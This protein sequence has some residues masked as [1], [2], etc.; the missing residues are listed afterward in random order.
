MMSSSS[1]LAIDYGRKR[2]G[3]AVSRGSL[4]DPLQTLAMDTDFWQK[5]SQVCE[6]E[7]VKLVVVGVSEQDMACESRR[8]GEEVA[9]KIQL[10]VKFYD[11]TL[12]SVVVRGKLSQLKSSKSRGFIDHFAAA[13]ILQNFLDE[14]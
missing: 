7:N 13:E 9:K 2:V 8:F 11:E 10:P 14:Q 12:S 5:L 3:L 6:E 1:I 4:A